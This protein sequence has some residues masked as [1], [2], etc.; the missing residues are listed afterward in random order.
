MTEEIEGSKVS[1]GLAKNGQSNPKTITLV[2]KYCYYNP[3]KY[4]QGIVIIK[5]FRN[6]S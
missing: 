1:V 4:Y 2:S 3:T 6:V 5:V